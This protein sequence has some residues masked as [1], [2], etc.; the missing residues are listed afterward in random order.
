[1]TKAHE[2]A[3]ANSQQFEK[4][5]DDLL[6]I[7]SISTLPEC[8]GDVQQAAEWVAA[9]MRRIGLTTVEI[10][11]TVGHPVVY[12]EWLGAGSDKPTVLV[13]GHYDVQPA[14]KSDGWD[15][16][17]F[18]PVI[19]DGKIWARGSSDDKG[20]ML[21]QL[22]AAE[23]LLANGGKA[24]ANMKFLIEGEEEI[25][26]TNLGKFVA[27]NRD[28]LK[29]DVCV[30]SDSGMKTIDQP[31]IDYSTRGLM[32]LDF[33]VFGPK[34]D[35]HSGGYGGIVH[36][37]AQAMAEIIAQL[38][39]PDG[40]VN[41]P[42]FYDD[43]LKMSDEERAELRS[44]AASEADWKA[45]TGVPQFW[46]EAGYD[47]HER[48]GGRPTLEING[49]VS[50]FYGEGSKTV[51]PAKALAKISCR[52]V[53]NQDPNKIYELVKAHLLKLTPPTVRSEVRQQAGAFPA[54]MDTHSSA[55]QAAM[56]A[57][58]KGWGK[59]PVFERGG[60]TLPIIA[61]F[62]RQLNNLPVILMGLGLSSDGAHGPNENFTLEM[63]HKG[64]DT[65]IYFY[66][67][68]GK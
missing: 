31:V 39:N 66:E 48:I 30:I 3:K 34:Q 54:V 23:S 32:Y 41:V 8:K 16:E 47:L 63:F 64:I 12:G 4:Q 50:G 25:G 19:H 29:A 44:H 21:A 43:V 49:F 45:A 13:Y 1:M 67:E 20:Q 57:F 55:M 5:L 42:G 17:P 10:L 68:L 36:N 37:P 15:N 53:P 6:R 22:K 46:G 51:L 26:S 24:P 38:H 28:K 40:S 14:V 2:Y 52:L 58:E 56:T 62:Q 9:D 33:E 60:G 65:A 7:K 35:L 61:D 18:E 59:R 11:Q 27:A